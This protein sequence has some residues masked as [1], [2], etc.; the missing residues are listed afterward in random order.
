VNVCLEVVEAERSLLVFY[1][2]AIEKLNVYRDIVLLM[3][4]QIFFILID[5]R[6]RHRKGIAMYNAT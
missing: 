3:E 1:V 5:Y 4:H 6:G 2:Y